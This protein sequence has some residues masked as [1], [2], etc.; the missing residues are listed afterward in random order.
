M[1]VQSLIDKIR[2]LLHD[3]DAI[4]WT[5]GELVGW[6]NDAQREISVYKPDICVANETINLEPGSKQSLPTGGLTLIDAIRSMTSTGPARAVK[7]VPRRILDAQ[8]PDWHQQA[9][10]DEVIGVCFDDR[11]QKTFYVWPPSTG[12]VNSRLEIV[13]A[14]TPPDV[15][16]GSSGISI[17]DTY[18]TAI[19]SYVAYRAYSKD[20][21][22]AADDSRAASHY[23]HFVS[24]IGGKEAG[25]RSIEAKTNIRRGNRSMVSDGQQG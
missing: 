12:A 13:Y 7:L 8:R 16:I 20:S 24:L 19:I 10:A 2:I 17:D 1:T 9:P 23:S 22:Y 11:D 4:N 25:E 21:D 3:A 18:A 6:L 15:T 14:K 5:D